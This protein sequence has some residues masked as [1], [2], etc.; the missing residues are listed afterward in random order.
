MKLKIDIEHQFVYKMY[1]MNLWKLQY[2]G[3]IF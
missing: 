1:I 2:Y 3:C